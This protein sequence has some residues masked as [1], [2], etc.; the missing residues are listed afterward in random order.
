M[1]TSLGIWALGSDGVSV[2]RNHLDF[3]GAVSPVESLY[4][5]AFDDSSGAI[6][7]N[8]IL[9]VRMA[10]ANF[11]AQTGIG[12]IATGTGSVDI[13]SNVIR[14]YQKGGIVAGRV[15]IPLVGTVNILDNTVVGV[16]PTP[17]IAQNGIQVSGPEAS[18]LVRGNHIEGNFYTGC[19]HQDAAKTGC[20]PWEATGLLLWD[21]F[22]GTLLKTADNHYVDNQRNFYVLHAH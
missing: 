21:V 13:L 2:E 12:V 18:G 22:H 1:K 20:I 10:T 3:G 15:S 7:G 5:V 4:G 17:L 14:D 19:S 9:H 8:T 6:S 11:G 16:G